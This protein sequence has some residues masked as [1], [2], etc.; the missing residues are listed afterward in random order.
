MSDNQNLTRI[1]VVHNALEDLAD[2][3]VFVGGATLSLYR[4]RPAEE[5]RPTD[6]VDIIIE[7]IKYEDYAN[8]EEQLRKKGFTN[9]VESGV[10]CRYIVQGI[11]V[12]VMPTNE[13]ILGFANRWYVDGF[14]HSM[15]HDID[16]ETTVRIFSPEYFIAS[17][18]EA[19]LDRGNNDG[20]MSSD[21]EDIVYVLNN[22]STI[23]DEL[24]EADDEL[25]D[26]LTITFQKL[27]E[28]DVLNEWISGHLEFNEQRRVDYI[29]QGINDFIL[30]V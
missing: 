1:K 9:D 28:E 8:I 22:R 14:E 24:K 5:A 21:F 30:N 13:D 18:L 7:L 17:K 16:E 26:F 4:D 23:W 20:R 19:F 10:I 2:K 12:D 25:K 11:V 3:V 27:I 15:E 6:D 29:I